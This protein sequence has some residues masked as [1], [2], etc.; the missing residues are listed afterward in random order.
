LKPHFQA[1]GALG[2]ADARMR[3]VELERRV[4]DGVSVEEAAR[5]VLHPST[6]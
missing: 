4:S 5:Q 1:A 3:E 6:V 2:H